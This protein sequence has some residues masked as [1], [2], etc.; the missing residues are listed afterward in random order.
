MIKM[1]VN[2]ERLEKYIKK[3][4]AT[5]CPL[6]GN[7]Q[8]LFSD[9]LFQLMEFDTKG[10]LIEGAVFPVVPLTCGNCGNTYF[11]NVIS[12]G[13]IEKQKIEEDQDKNGKTK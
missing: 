12:A 1:K 11:I 2:K 7:N 13:L 3:I 4:H 10:M 8:W 5:S 9:T 6:C